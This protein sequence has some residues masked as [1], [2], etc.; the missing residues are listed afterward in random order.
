MKG[1]DESRLEKRRKALDDEMEKVKLK[2][3][4]T[5]GR[6]K[7]LNNESEVE[8]VEG[9]IDKIIHFKELDLQIQNTFLKT[10]INHVEYVREVPDDVGKNRKHNNALE[11][12]PPRIRIQY[13]Q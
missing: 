3:E 10:I 2:T 13:R 7:Q 11:Q 5:K 8:R 1:F 12:Y 6:L 9:L 4:E